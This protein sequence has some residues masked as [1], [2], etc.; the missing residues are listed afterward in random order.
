MTDTTAKAGGRLPD[1]VIRPEALVRAVLAAARQLP[2]STLVI[3]VPLP[4]RA[5][6]VILAP[7]AGRRTDNRAPGTE[8]QWLIAYTA[9][10]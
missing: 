6:H 3:P 1:L 8:K 5:E 4:P 10:C 2:D 9:G 7:L